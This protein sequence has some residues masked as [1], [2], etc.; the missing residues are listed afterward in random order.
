MSSIDGYQ[1][2]MHQR[3]NMNFYSGNQPIFLSVMLCVLAFWACNKSLV[4][5]ESRLPK[6]SNWLC[7][8][9][10]TVDPA[11]LAPFELAVLDADA[12]VDLQSIKNNGTTVVGYVSLAEVQPFRWY[13]EL[14]QN[15]GCILPDKTAFGGYFVD[16]RADSWHRL[17]LDKI[18][19]TIMEKGFDGL[20]LDTIDTAEFLE[21]RQS[22]EQL[23]GARDAMIKLISD[24]RQ[25]FPNAVIIANRG[26]SMLPKFS[27]S[28][29]VVLAESVLTEYKSETGLAALRAPDS[30]AEILQKLKEFQRNGGL[31]FTL[32]YTVN[33]SPM[34]NNKVMKMA[35][36][37]NFV[38]YLSD[39]QLNKIYYTALGD[40]HGY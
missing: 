15:A 17:L 14:A 30:Y 32:D 39:P 6:I 1:V 33:S 2:G 40:Q 4:R 11:G 7:L 12:L 3:M 19:P 24:I 18:L 26:F 27:S 23:P 16:V 34:I 38:P 9:S 28:V 13:W 25:A 36:D 5:P 37:L 21:N 8:Y 31:V 22:G 20:F 35:E 29:D 10:N